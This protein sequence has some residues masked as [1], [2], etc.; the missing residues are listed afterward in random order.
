MRDEYGKH[1]SRISFAFIPHPL[2]S[3]LLFVEALDEIDVLAPVKSV[4]AE[5]VNQVAVVPVDHRVDER[6]PCLRELS[7]QFI[8]QG[9][10]HALPM[11]I[12]VNADDLQPAGEF[13]GELPAP[14]ISEDEADD[15][16]QML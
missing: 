9:A 8:H 5:I 11:I 3:S 14:H 15:F 6:D 12:R 4:G 13:R 10:A 2:A 7:K 1:S 16:V